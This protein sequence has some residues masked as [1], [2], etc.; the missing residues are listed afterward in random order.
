MTPDAPKKNAPDS[1][2][3]EEAND[4]LDEF[5]AE[6][7]DGSPLMPPESRKSRAQ[8]VQEPAL[9]WS[10]QPIR[11][12]EPD[13]DLPLRAEPVVTPGPLMTPGPVVAP[14]PVVPPEPTV[15]VGLDNG[16]DASVLFGWVR[17]AG[18]IAVAVLVL[19][20]TAAGIVMLRRSP[21]PSL[22]DL[23]APAVTIPPLDA[24]AHPTPVTPPV[25]RES[26]PAGAL[27]ESAGAALFRSHRD[28][29]QR[30]HEVRKDQGHVRLRRDQQG[31]RCLCRHGDREHQ[32]R[33]RRA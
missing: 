7:A 3:L 28:R 18:R 11:R 29:L 2:R 21:A 25:V 33:A 4:G 20:M 31:R 23:S 5:V 1:V 15:G 13:L 6:Y 22:A 32:P 17:L 26:Q 8:R 9:L 24:S 16:W 14:Q 10:D 12:Y 27:T 19:A 30:G